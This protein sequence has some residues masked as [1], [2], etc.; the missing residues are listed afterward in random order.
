[1]MTLQEANALPIPE[2]Y[3]DTP[4]IYRLARI[5]NSSQ[6]R[7]KIMAALPLVLPHILNPPAEQEK[8]NPMNDNQETGGRQA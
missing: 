3:K 5:I 7:D 1:M 2:Q 8:D 6:H 4:N